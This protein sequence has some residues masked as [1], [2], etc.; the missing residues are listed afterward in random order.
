MISITNTQRR[1]TIDTAQ[2][3]RHLRAMLHTLN[4]DNFAI[5]VLICGEKR[6]AQ[7]NEQYRGKK[8]ATDILSFPY[9]TNLQPGEGITVAN[10]EDKNLGDII[11]CPLIID[12]KRHAWGHNF[13]TQLTMILAHGIAHLLNYDHHTDEQFAIMQEVEKKL[14][15]AVQ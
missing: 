6:M 10:D 13:K 2:I 1:F 12:R 3:E 7:Y 15:S 14:L 11:L 8:G 4:Y 9:H 5:G